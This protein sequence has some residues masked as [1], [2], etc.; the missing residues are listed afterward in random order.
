[1]TINLGLYEQLVTEE[2]QQELDKLDP[3]LEI[4]FSK[5]DAGESPFVIG[6]YLGQNIARLLIKITGNTTAT[7]EHL[8]L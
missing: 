3:C 7:F 2:L 6:Q 5:L 1:M 4:I 8:I